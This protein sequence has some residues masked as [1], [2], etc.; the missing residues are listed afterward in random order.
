MYYNTNDAPDK[1]AREKKTRVQDNRVMEIIRIYEQGKGITPR[2]VHEQMGGYAVIELTSVRRSINS[3][4]AE[5]K[6]IK[7][8]EKRKND[9]G[10]Q[11]CVWKVKRENAQMQLL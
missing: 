6:L 1:P 8:G 2:F 11:E 3:L 9:K 5:G 10:S 4:T 7:T